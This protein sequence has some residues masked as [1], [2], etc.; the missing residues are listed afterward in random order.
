MERPCQAP[1]GAL[2]A[3]GSR[4]AG[5]APGWGQ[6]DGG[7]DPSSAAFTSLRL[8][9][10]D[11]NTVQGMLKL[12]VLAQDGASPGG[13]RAASSL[14]SGLL[15]PGGATLPGSGGLSPSTGSTATAQGGWSPIELDQGHLPRAAPVPAPPRPRTR[16]HWATAPLGPWDLRLH[17][18]TSQAGRETTEASVSP[19]LSPCPVTMC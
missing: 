10:T 8:R 19:G 2:V 1:R 4:M 6:R 3:E 5:S 12:P 18:L 15:P 7:P 11:S 13:S 9:T 16:A 14:H 17:A